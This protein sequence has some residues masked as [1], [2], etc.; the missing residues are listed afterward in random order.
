MNRFDCSASSLSRPD[1]KSLSFC[2]MIYPSQQF[3]YV[4]FL[5]DSIRLLYVHSVWIFLNWQIITVR[6]PFHRIVSAYNGKIRPDGP[7]FTHVYE[8]LSRRINRRYKNLRRK[9]SERN[10]TY[11]GTATFEDFVNFLLYDRNPKDD[12]WNLYD[13]IC[14]PCRHSYDFIAKFETL[15]EDL[16]YLEHLFNISSEHKKVFFPSRK[17]RTNDEMVRQYFARI[18]VD[19]AI[20]LYKMYANDFM[21]FGYDKPKWLVW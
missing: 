4:C 3:F 14:T 2:L 11:D 16:A 5:Y 6:D 10:E 12:H 19:A 20:S 9:K 21:I 13:V 15:S 17:M 1:I 8:P 18:P 7:G